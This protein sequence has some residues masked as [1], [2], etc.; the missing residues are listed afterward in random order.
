MPARHRHSSPLVIRGAQLV[1]VFFLLPFFFSFGHFVFSHQTAMDLSDWLA[2]L[3][4]LH[5]HNAAPIDHLR[6]ELSMAPADLRR[7][8]ALSRAETDVARGDADVA[9]P[10]P[11]D[12]AA[13]NLQRMHM[14]ATNRCSSGEA[15]PSMD[16]RL[17]TAIDRHRAE[18][19]RELADLRRRK[20][21][22]DLGQR[23]RVV[24]AR[25]QRIVLEGPC[26]G[27]DAEA[28]HAVLT[29]R[30]DLLC[31][32]VPARQA[33]QLRAVVHW[34]GYGNPH[35][36]ACVDGAKA[37]VRA[38]A[39]SCKA[40]A[41]R[42]S[43]KQLL[44]VLAPSIHAKFCRSRRA[45]LAAARTAAVMA[46]QVLGM[47]H[48]QIERAGGG[49]LDLAVPLHAAL[50]TPQARAVPLDRFFHWLQTPALFAA[51][52]DQSGFVTWHRA[53][54]TTH[55]VASARSRLLRACDGDLGVRVPAG[56][57]GGLRDWAETDLGIGRATATSI[58]G[59]VF[60]QPALCRADVPADTVMDQRRLNA[61]GFVALVCALA[62][63]LC[64]DDPLTV[65]RATRARH[66]AVVRSTRCG[67]ALRDVAL[68]PE[69]AVADLV[70]RR[71]TH[72]T[73]EKAAAAAVHPNFLHDALLA[74][75]AELRATAAT[76]DAAAATLTDSD[77][78]RRLRTCGATIAA[79]R[80][81]DAWRSAQY[82]ALV[83]AAAKTAE[84]RQRARQRAR[85]V[86]GYA[87]LVT[88]ALAAA[89]ALTAATSRKRKQSREA[90]AE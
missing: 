63:F 31:M 32:T 58:V 89:A 62:H 12:R 72:W 45:V 83:G 49:R 6:A 85:R 44:K 47:Q 42:H 25:L 16:P 80:Q 37:R 69:Y 10:H 35:V 76:A 23:Q 9:G 66:A 29:A 79:A 27:G 74:R 30:L 51:L 36:R 75:V 40:K 15:P 21:L 43:F 20:A 17:R 34:L 73:V 78:L 7:L 54:A 1:C 26:N 46:C 56:N 41:A 64:G 71:N 57:A 18:M 5:R 8:T 48:D 2:L 28:R 4:T 81:E 11:G 19:A 84:A 55:V 68:E 13:W 38:E 14:L 59:G 86:T 52:L 3:R 87:A 61:V 60:R 67:R 82:A 22:C 77:V 50:A 90:V 88:A 65:P 24:A 39:S 53:P 70:C 33:G